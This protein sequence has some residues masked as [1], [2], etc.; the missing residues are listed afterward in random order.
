[1]DFHKLKKRWARSTPAKIRR[2]RG[3]CLS[4]FSE[5]QIGITIFSQMT[6]LLVVA[7]MTRDSDRMAAQISR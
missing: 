4:F 5:L 7:Q 3:S 6:K 2:K 1:M